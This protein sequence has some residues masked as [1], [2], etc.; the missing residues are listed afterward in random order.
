MSAGTTLAAG[1][2]GIF[3]EHVAEDPDLEPEFQKDAIGIIGTTDG[4]GDWAGMYGVFLSDNDF[5][6][7]DDSIDYGGAVP[8][9][10]WDFVIWEHD[11]DTGNDSVTS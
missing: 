7:G 1:T 4:S 5:V 11:S 9:N 2:W 10:A 3:I 8:D 6:P